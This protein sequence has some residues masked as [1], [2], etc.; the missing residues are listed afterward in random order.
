MVN[1]TVSLAKKLLGSEVT[2]NTVSPG[3]ILTPALERTARGIAKM[4][5]WGEDWRSV[6]ENF[7]K[8]V[9]QNPSNR[10]GRVE[11]IATMVTFLASPLTDFVNG[12]NIRVDGGVT[13]SIN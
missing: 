6:E 1:T 12:A 11:D 9:V 13:K 4:Q 5:G 2:V 10:I 7:V 3:P 8:Y